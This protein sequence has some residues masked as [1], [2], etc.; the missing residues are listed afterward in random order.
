M[1]LGDRFT[2]FIVSVVLVAAGYKSFQAAEATDLSDKKHWVTFW[3]LYG[4][5]QFV[6]FFVDFILYWVPFYNELKLGLF[7]YLA[8]LGGAGKVYDTVGKK[9]FMAAEKGVGQV[10]EKG[11]ANEQYKMA[12]EK[13]NSLL[14][15]KKHN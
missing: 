14:P 12:C 11:M 3:M 7:I 8:F 4:V 2:A 15:K 5:V 6:E 9:G 10:H 13:V 1:L